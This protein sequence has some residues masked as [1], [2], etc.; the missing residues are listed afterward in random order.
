MIDPATG[1]FETASISRKRADC[2]ANCLE[3]TWLT[4]YPWPTEI[5]MD[6]GSEFKLEVSDALKD[7]YGIN[8]KLITTRNPQANSIVERVHQTVHNLLKVSQMDDSDDCDEDFGFDGILS[9]V[10]RAVNSTVHATLRATP[11]QLVFG[12]DALL[13]LSLIHI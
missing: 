6:R 9:A 8:K 5:V 2:I 13:N 12:H 10:R 4:R 7:E 1:W 3:M 11:T